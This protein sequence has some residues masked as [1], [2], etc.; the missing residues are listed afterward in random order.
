MILEAEGHTRVRAQ[1]A[2]EQ[3]L[4]V[5]HAHNLHTVNTYHTLGLAKHFQYSSNI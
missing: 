3:E 4:A 2:E 1:E 5:A